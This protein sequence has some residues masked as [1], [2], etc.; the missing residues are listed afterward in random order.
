MNY[1]LEFKS[2]IPEVDS[3][4]LGTFLIATK[5]KRDG[6]VRT[7]PAYYLNRYPLHFED[8][9]GEC[10]PDNCS[11]ENLDGCPMSGWFYDESNLDYENC[12]YPVSDEV[13]K[14]SAIPQYQPES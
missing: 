7:F 3:G 8:D 14:W 12:Y 6:K 1:S 9:C 5:S 4:D 11:A 13:L 10:T 2:G